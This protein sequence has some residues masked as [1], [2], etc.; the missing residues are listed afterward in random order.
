MQTDVSFE[1]VLNTPLNYKIPATPINV[2]PDEEKLF[3]AESNIKLNLSRNGKQFLVVGEELKM[4]RDKKLYK[5]RQQTFEDYCENNLKISRYTG[6]RFIQIYEFV[7]TSQHSLNKYQQ[8]SYSQLCEMISIQDEKILSQITPGTT[9]KQIR[10]LKQDALKPIVEQQKQDKQAEKI[11]KLDLYMQAKEIAE[12]DK[13]DLPKPLVLK[14]ITERKKFLADFKTWKQIAYIQQISLQ[15]YSYDLKNGASILAFY[16]LDSPYTGVKYTL[17]IR[18]KSID[19]GYR[20]VLGYLNLSWNSENEIID[21]LTK[22]K[23]E[24]E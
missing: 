9:I 21:W 6:F 1:E 16:V 3:I 17:Y 13:K 10:K 22:H 11:E 8:Y 7:A 18:S 19:Y 23:S 15:I 12:A 5:L 2:T 14:N 4:I 24:I 20:F